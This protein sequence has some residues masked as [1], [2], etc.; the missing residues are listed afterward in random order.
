MAFWSLLS[1]M[2]GEVSA[3]DEY[4]S[5]TRSTGP[6]SELAS[7]QPGFATRVSTGEVGDTTQSVDQLL[8]TEPGIT[9][10]SLGGLGEFATVSIRGSAADHVLVLLDGVPL[11]GAA[12][13]EVDV[14]LVPADLLESIDVYRSGAPVWVGAAP[15]GG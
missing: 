11:S 4:A 8:Q 3:Q 6:S 10:R 15:M 2:A 7:E 14:N 13:G 1:G 5:E 9:V 12:F